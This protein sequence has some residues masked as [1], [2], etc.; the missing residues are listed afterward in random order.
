MIP[1]SGSG[2]WTVPTGALEAIRE[3]GIDAVEDTTWKNIWMQFR[4]GKIDHW[5]VIERRPYWICWYVKA[6]NILFSEVEE[7][8][9]NRILKSLSYQQLISEASFRAAGFSSSCS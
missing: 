3:D 6:E 5:N 7:R 8:Q 4:T 9:G 1:A 2:F